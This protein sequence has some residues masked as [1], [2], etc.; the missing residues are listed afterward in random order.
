[1]YPDVLIYIQ[2][3][4]NFFEKNEETKNYFIRH[5]DEEI[6]FQKLTKISQKNFEEKGDPMLTQEEFE[7][8]KNTLQKNELKE[9]IHSKIHMKLGNFGTICLN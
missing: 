8:L 3:V 1:M 5:T 7:E 6:F 2:S 9:D 4:K